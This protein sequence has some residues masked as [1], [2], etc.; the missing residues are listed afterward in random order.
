MRGD[1]VCVDQRLFQSGG[2]VFKKV[3]CQGSNAD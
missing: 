1:G 3:V 2:K